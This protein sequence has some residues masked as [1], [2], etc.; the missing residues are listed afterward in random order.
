LKG[1]DTTTLRVDKAEPENV[2]FYSYYA[3]TE[4]QPGVW[5]DD[6]SEVAELKIF[7]TNSPLVVYGTPIAG[8]GGSGTSC[9]GAYVSYVE[10]TNA[11]D[12]TGGWYFKNGGKAYD[13]SG[14]TD[15]VARYYGV[16]Y[17]NSKCSTTRSGQPVSLPIPD[18]FQSEPAH[19]RLSD[20]LGSE[21]SPIVVVD[22]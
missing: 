11:L 21:V 2:G 4:V 12:R 3:E 17:T 20:H 22:C 5:A 13:A 8:Q 14:R 18:L 1:Y 15:T 7:T 19:R 6:Y 16:P 9:P 10:Y